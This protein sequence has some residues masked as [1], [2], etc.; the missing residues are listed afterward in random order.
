MY[1]P[2]R[3]K[4]VEHLLRTTRRQ[5]QRILHQAGY[6]PFLIPARDVTIDLISD[7]GTG[8]MTA[9]QWASMVQ[10]REDF[11]GQTA[12]GTFVAAARTVTGFPFIL[13]VHGGRVAENILFRLLLKPGDTTIANTHFETT[14]GNIESL[15][16]RPIDACSDEPPF[17]G[18]IDITTLEKCARSKKK[19]RLLILTLTNNIYG[20]Q[21]V[22][23]DNIIRAA[24]IARARGI[25]LLLDGCRFADNAYLIKE[26][27]GSRKSVRRLS[28]MMFDLGDVLYLSSKKDGLS[29][30]GGFIAVRD[31]HLYDR[32]RYEVLRQESFP[33]SGGL[34]ARDM[35][36]MASGLV[37]GLDEEQLRSHIGHVRFLA[38]RLEQAGVRVFR[39]VGG[40]AVV[41]IPKA[42]TRHAAFA[43]AAQLY[44]E[45]GV[46]VGVFDDLV[47]LAVPRR[48]YTRDHMEYVALSLGKVCAGKLPRLRTAYRPAEFKNFFIRFTRA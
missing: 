20:G 25:T 39:P 8:A 32:L 9:Q 47:R 2:Y 37:D 26:H 29:N 38:D 35:A 34:A 41:V 33:T 48:V 11:A 17:L 13:P 43:L 44:L 5:R 3:I 18:D 30:I 45:N 42:R 12:H 7:S 4:V 1:E 6:N 21:P 23:M 28:R 19:P 27:S 14:R 31:K 24:R 40:H 36:A 15:G 10:A 46:R 16:C 22:S